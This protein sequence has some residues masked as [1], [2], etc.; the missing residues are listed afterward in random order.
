M[1]RPDLDSCHATRDH[2]MGWNSDRSVKMLNFQWDVV[3]W[4]FFFF[5]FFFFLWF[6]RRCRRPYRVRSE[7]YNL[8]GK[9]K[10]GIKESDGLILHAPLLQKRTAL[11]VSVISLF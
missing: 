8:A 4:W 9:K 6:C 1:R 11:A 10:R 3:E 2:E 7:N 5:F